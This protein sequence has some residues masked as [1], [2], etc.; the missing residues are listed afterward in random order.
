M[1]ATERELAEIKLVQKSTEDLSKQY[2]EYNPFYK[3]YVLK[4]HCF[5]EELHYDIEELPDDTKQQLG[6]AGDEIQKFLSKHNDNKYLLIIEGQASKNSEAWTDRNYDLSF[7]RAYSL[8]KYWKDV[9]GINF[10]KNCEVQ[11]A[12]SGDGR[13]NIE[14]MRDK[15]YEVNNQRFLIHIIP[16]NIIEDE[17]K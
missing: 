3:K 7:E 1:E 8:M 17:K 15:M 14:T 4:V 11:I 13:Y 9:C 2:F 5:F 12:G 10:G 6:A 16:K